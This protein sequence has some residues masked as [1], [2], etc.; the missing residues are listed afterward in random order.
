MIFKPSPRIEL[1]K[2][3]YEDITDE[4]LNWL[5][6]QRVIKYLEVR[7][8]DRSVDAIK[9]WVNSFDDVS[10]YLWKIVD[11]FESK[12]VGTA[13]LHSINAFHKRASYGYMI[14]DLDYWDGLT[15]YSACCITFDFAFSNL[16]LN[17]LF[18]G[19]YSSNISAIVN[20]KKLG[21]SYQGVRKSSLRVEESWVDEILFG[22]TRADWVNTSFYKK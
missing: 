6:D 7:N 19:T 21:L 17:S 22:I 20:Y 5:Y 10:A 4:Y 9:N 1:Q 18:A 11:V 3:T 8:S 12:T 13:S 15:A 2:F 16:E 14:G